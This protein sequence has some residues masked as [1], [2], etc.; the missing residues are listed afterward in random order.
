MTLKER[1]F[2]TLLLKLWDTKNSGISFRQLLQALE[3]GKF[4]RG[5]PYPPCSGPCG[6][7]AYAPVDKGCISGEV[8]VTPR[9][10]HYTGNNMLVSNDEIREGKKREEMLRAQVKA[11][12]KES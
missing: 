9:I 6:K 1:V 5:G 2:L 10:Q 8:H 4:C 7:A 3:I 12:N 11:Y